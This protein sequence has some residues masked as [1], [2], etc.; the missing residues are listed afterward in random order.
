MA[1][2]RIVRFF[3]DYRNFIGGFWPEGAQ[4]QFALREL[5]WYKLTRAIVEYAQADS[6]DKIYCYDA[7]PGGE[8]P[9]D[10]R[11]L[12]SEM[13]RLIGSE[14]ENNAKFVVR[15]GYNITMSKFNKKGDSVAWTREKAVDTQ[16]VVD[17]T[18]G[19]LRGEYDVA[20]LFSGDLDMKPGIVEVVESGLECIVCGWGTRCVS[21]EILAY[22]EATEGVSYFDLTTLGAVP[23]LRVAELGTGQELSSGEFAM[24]VALY[25][26]QVFSGGAPVSALQLVQS[27]YLGLPAGESNRYGILRNLKQYGLVGI[28]SVRWGPH[29][30][31]RFI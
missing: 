3:V 2:E 4:K 19:A 13:R 7:F 25:I 22:I 17:M 9:K 23:I 18:R 31:V 10:V 5:D 27:N 1:E 24:C 8:M 26:A 6:Y 12:P 29:S 16:I 30:N 28:D 11:R 14:V 20:V 21:S 15:P